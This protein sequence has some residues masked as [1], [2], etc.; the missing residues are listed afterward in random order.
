MSI[1]YTKEITER[2]EKVGHASLFVF[3]EMIDDQFLSLVARQSGQ[4]GMDSRGSFEGVVP[5]RKDIFPALCFADRLN[6]ARLKEFFFVGRIGHRLFFPQVLAEIVGNLAGRLAPFQDD[7]RTG[8]EMID[9]FLL[10][11]QDQAGVREALIREQADAP[12]HLFKGEF[13]IIKPFPLLHPARPEVLQRGFIQVGNGL[14]VN[15]FA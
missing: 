15:D 5:V 10:S 6:H 4:T 8:Q 9:L 12:Q 2:I 7:L 11:E 3:S 1:C 14:T 13:R